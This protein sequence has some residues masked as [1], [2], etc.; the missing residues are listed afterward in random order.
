MAAQKAACQRRQSPKRSVDLSPLQLYLGNVRFVALT[1]P[2]CSEFPT[3][4]C[5]VCPLHVLR[6]LCSSSPSPLGLLCMC[7]TR[8][9]QSG[10]FKPCLAQL[11][12]GANAWDNGC[13]EGYSQYSEIYGLR[14]EEKAEIHQKCR[15]GRGWL[16]GHGHLWGVSEQ[17]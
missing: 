8:R 3:V 6:S 16:L 2:C 11:Q 14:Q 4:Q 7:Q 15:T 9:K 10:V 12:K 1:C 17:D 5:A 13:K